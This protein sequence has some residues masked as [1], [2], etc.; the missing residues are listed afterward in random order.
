MSSQT[1]DTSDSNSFSPIGNPT[2]R[3]AYPA[4]TINRVNGQARE[5]VLAGRWP[6]WT[7]AEA[8]RRDEPGEAL[9]HQADTRAFSRSL[10]GAADVALVAPFAAGWPLMSF[11]ELGALPGAVPCARLHARQV[12]WEWAL[13]TFTEST[14]LLVSELVSNAVGI[15][16]ASAPDSPVRVWLVSDKQHVLIVVWDASPQPPVRI[17]ADGE[18]EKGRGLMLV[19]AS[20]ARWGWGFPQRIG[21][22][23]VWA[24]AMP[25]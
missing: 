17:D 13:E 24:L 3:C 10:T 20:S 16:R 7:A 22:K 15:S 5:G 9:P 21:G 25:E 6:I 12:L 23:V 18:A 1:V 2:F 11:L 4:C 8:L 14:A 19:E